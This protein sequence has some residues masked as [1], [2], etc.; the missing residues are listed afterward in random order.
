MKKIWTLVLLSFFLQITS[1]GLAQIDGK[2]VLSADSF[3]NDA[4]W[5]NKNWKYKPGDNMDWAAPTFDDNDWEIANSALIPD[6]LPKDGWNGIGWFRLHLEVDETL[7]DQPLVL[8]S[9]QI[10]AAEIYLDGQLIYAFGK[11]GTSKATEKIDFTLELHPR[12]VEISFGNQ[13]HHVLA[14]RY[15]NF[16]ALSYKWTNIPQ[17]DFGMFPLIGF[18]MKIERGGLTRSYTRHADFVRRETSYQFFFVGAPLAFTLL[19]LLLFCFYPQLKENFYYAVFTGSYTIL[20]FALFEFIFSTDLRSGLLF[21]T[22]FKIAV[23]LVTGSGLRFSYALFRSQ[24]PKP[25]RILRAAGI[26][27]ALLSWYI[28]Q[29][30]VYLFSLIAFAEMLRVIFVAILKKKNGAWIIGI[31]SLAMVLTASYQMISSILDQSPDDIGY[32]YAYGVLASLIS[33]SV[34]LARRFAQTNKDLEKQSSALR[35]L[36]V[37]LE[38]R[39]EKRTAELAKSNQSLETKNVQLAESNNQIQT[40]HT[41]LQNTYNELQQTQTQLVQSEKMAALGHLA[42]GIAHE[43]NNPIGAVNSIADVSSRCVHKIGEILKTSESLDD[44]KKNKQFQR[45]LTLLEKNQQTTLT[46]SNRISEIVGSLKNFTRLDEADFQFADIHDGILST[47]TLL[48]NRLL[49]RITVYKEF[50]D[51]PKIRCYPGQLNQVFMHLIQNAADAIEGKG[52]V[53]IKTW[54]TGNFVKFSV[55]DDG[56][57]IPQNVLSK[58]FDPFFTTKPV[59]SGTGL[60]LTVS[61]QIIDR[62]GGKIEV[63]SEVGKGTE[64]VV[65]LPVNPPIET[66]SAT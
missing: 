46:A 10:G 14:V 20:T 62:H 5:I 28:P 21:F 6:K 27:L 64:F 61:H 59:G 4:I 50:A 9:A 33:M 52:E 39:V 58:V 40:A 3:K 31:G 37:E 54:L 1:M 65:T 38:D 55:R 7:W 57:G 53:S 60:G 43:I 15:S 63:E 12:I 36:N 13:T 41:Q 22:V 47:L 32:P 45:T 35:Q 16:S 26:V 49:N 23:I 42:A 8:N 19:H 24:L 18:E 17:L 51:L 11:V 29:N 44:L 48:N 66:T 34:Y 25:V 56:K 30:Y 2:I